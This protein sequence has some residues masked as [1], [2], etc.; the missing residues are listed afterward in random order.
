[1]PPDGS[2][3]GRTRPTAMADLGPV[4]LEEARRAV[5][6]GRGTVLGNDF[7]RVVIR[8]AGE[9]RTFP[10]PH[11]LPFVQPNRQVVKCRGF[12][13][14]GD[15]YLVMTLCQLG[16]CEDGS[17]VVREWVTCYFN[18]ECG[19]FNEGHY[20]DPD[21]EAEARRDFEERCKRYC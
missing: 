17:C 20:F 9:A 4:T 14:P 7:Q 12:R 8:Y 5:R 21:E 10:W 6:H 16:H 11:P 1:M 19:G 2:P 15:I 3:E 18:L 13:H